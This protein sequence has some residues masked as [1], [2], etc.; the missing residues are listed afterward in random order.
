[1]TQYT[2][3]KAVEHRDREYGPPKELGRGNVF[4][5]CQLLSQ[6]RVGLLPQSSQPFPKPTSGEFPMGSG[7]LHFKQA[8]SFTCSDSSTHI[9]LRTILSCLNADYLALSK[10]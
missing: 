5:C 1:M 3:H 6:P 10:D 2:I 9:G 4:S 8:S 7:D